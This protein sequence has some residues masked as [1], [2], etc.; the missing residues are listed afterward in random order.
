MYEITVKVSFS[1]AHQLRGHPGPCKNVHGHNWVVEAYY[2]SEKL[3]EQAM[4]IDF[5]DVDRELRRITQKLDHTMINDVP[6]FDKDNPTAEKIAEWI[7]DELKNTLL[8]PPSRITVH[9]TDKAAAS[10]FL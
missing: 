9:E 7:F 10:Y 8:M 1:A 6:P 2:R 5:A 3:D 4:V